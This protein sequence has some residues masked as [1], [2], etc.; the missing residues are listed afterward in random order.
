M[1]R[2]DTPT[3]NPAGHFHQ[4]N[5]DLDIP[6]TLLSAAWFESVQEELCN[7]VEG[8]GLTLNPGNKTQLKTAIDLLISRAGVAVPAGAYLDHAGTS[9][10]AGYVLADGRLL[11]IDSCP[12]LYAA[13]GNLHNAGV[14]PVGSFRLPDGRGRNRIGAGSGVGLTHRTPGTIGGAETHT[15][16]VDEM[17]EHDHDRNPDGREEQVDFLVGATVLGNYSADELGVD[18][19][20]KTGPA[21]HSEAHN[22]MPPF[23]AAVA[24]VKLGLFDTPVYVD[25]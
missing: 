7:V 1:Q 4:G 20:T 2:I 11:S 15:L 12:G 16:T 8:A 6:P 23:L 25:E 9:A 18:L 13:I 19:Y 14:V 22:N 5:V 10:P 3:A 24:C 17:P 21:G